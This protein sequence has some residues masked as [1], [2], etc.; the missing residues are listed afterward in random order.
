MAAVCLLCALGYGTWRMGAEEHQGTLRIAVVQGNIEQDKKWDPAYRT[1]VL[2]TYR[3]LTREALAQKPDLVIWP[4]T[5][6]PFYFGGNRRDDP[7]L[8][9]ELRRFVQSIGVPLLTGSPT[10]EQRGRRYRLKNSAFLLGTGG[11]TESVYHKLH[12]V[13]FGEYV[14]LRNSLLFFIDKL[15]QGSG[16]F[17]AGSEH[18]VT[19]V[20]TAGTG[21]VN[22]S[23]VICYEIVFPDI[24]RRFVDRGAQ[25]MTTITNDAWFGRTGAPYQHFSMAV[26]RAVENRVPVARAAN[27]GISGFIDAKGR[28]LEASPV[29][30]E[31]ALVRDLAPSDGAKTFY[32]RFGDVFA[33]LCVL[34]GIVLLAYPSKD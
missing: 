1:A 23:T 28:I 7:E 24:V 3:R 17:E 13:P 21:A 6:T 26:F 25:V 18:T 8:T 31:A 14:P 20:R 16:D 27:T 33:W 5:A 29:F 12:L 19:S 32:T 15:V 4:E 30:T 9:E 11:S 34:A 10:Y 2:D 22:I